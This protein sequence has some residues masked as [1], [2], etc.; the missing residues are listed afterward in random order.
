MMKNGF[1][2]GTANNLLNFNNRSVKEVHLERLCVLLNCTPNDLYVW[3][4]DNKLPVAEDHPIRS[5]ARTSS[6]TPLEYLKELPLEKL[7]EIFADEADQSS[8]SD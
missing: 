4:P 2:R 3:K 5:L 1:G 6:K 8:P 7:D